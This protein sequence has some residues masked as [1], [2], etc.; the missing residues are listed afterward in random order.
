MEKKKKKAKKKD[1]NILGLQRDPPCLS[2]LV[3]S[4]N[5]QAPPPKVRTR[6]LGSC[7]I[8]L[9][10]AC[11]TFFILPPFWFHFVMTAHRIFNGCVLIFYY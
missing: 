11:L 8:H 2:R 7:T 5:R 1:A 10:N 3:R 4:E 6:L 9:F